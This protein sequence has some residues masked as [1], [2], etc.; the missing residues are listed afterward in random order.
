MIVL[1]FNLD[2]TVAVD[3]S[4][5]L[6]RSNLVAIKINN[7]T[8]TSKDLFAMASSCKETNSA[9]IALKKAKIIN[10]SHKSDY[11]K[12]VNMDL[13]LNSTITKY[14]WTNIFLQNSNDL[15]NGLKLIEPIFKSLDLLDSLFQESRMMEIV[16]KI[17][18][19]FEHQESAIQRVEDV[20][21]T[22][23]AQ[24]NKSFDKLIECRD[25]GAPLLRFYN[26][27]CSQTAKLMDSNH[28][29]LFL[30]VILST[31]VPL[32][33]IQVFKN[34]DDGDDGKKQSI[35]SR[36][37]TDTGIHFRPMPRF[38]PFS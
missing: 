26:L 3:L 15:V 35:S 4:C 21:S 5:R 19:L 13:N 27:L 14:S 36:I 22:K 31:G 30:I 25:L 2:V 34:K 33:L 38:G 8:L 10:S 18:H 6:L 20:L 17:K 7:H 32:L 28:F 16:E 1:G 12:A 23:L 37:K 24:I 9:L 29:A 11:I